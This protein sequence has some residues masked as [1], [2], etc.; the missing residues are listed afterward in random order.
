MTAGQ[1]FEGVAGGNI[2][3]H[4]FKAGMRACAAQLREDVRDRI[5]DA[6]ISVRRPSAIIWPRE[7][8]RLVRLSA[9]R[10]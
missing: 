10:A 2:L 4:R 5:A 6:G 8:T 9:A 7:T 1:K 3:A